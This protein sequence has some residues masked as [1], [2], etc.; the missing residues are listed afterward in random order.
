[1]FRGHEATGAAYSLTTIYASDKFVTTNVT[2]STY[3]FRKQGAIVGGAG[4]VW[5]GHGDSIQYARIDGGP[6]NPGY[7]TDIA[8]KP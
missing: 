2:K 7:F 8:D 3:M 6:D 1:M 5:A 4:T